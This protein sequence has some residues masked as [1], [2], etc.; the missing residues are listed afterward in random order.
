MPQQRGKGLGGNLQWYFN[1]GNVVSPGNEIPH[2]YSRTISSKTSHTDIHII[3]R[4]QSN[5]SSSRQYC[6]LNIFDE[7]GRYSKSEN[8]RIGQGNLGISFEVGDHNYY[9]I[10]PKRIECNSRLGI[11]KH[12]GLL[13]VDAE[14]SN[15]SESLSG[16]GFSRDRFVCIS[17]IT[18]DT[19]LRCMEARSSQSCN[20]CISTELV[21]QTPVCFIPILHDSTSSPQNTQ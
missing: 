20:S 1:R 17:S 14:S 19:N 4:C 9:R 6:G 7:H 5:T 2:H 8:G 16:K 18:S 11:L 15:F 3:Q 21:T 10:A 13:R 12:F